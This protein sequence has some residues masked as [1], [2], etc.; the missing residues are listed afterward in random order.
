MSLWYPTA[1]VRRY[2]WD[3]GEMKGGAPKIVL[4]TTESSTV[5][6]YGGFLNIKNV[7]PHFTLD[8]SGVVFQ[9]HPIN[10]AA[11]ALRN[12]AGGVETNRQGRYCV[13]IEIVGYA[14]NGSKLPVK[15]MASLRALVKWIRSETGVKANYP[16]KIGG[17]FCYGYKS[18]CRMKYAYWPVFNGVCGHQHVPENTHWDPGA[19]NFA[20]LFVQPTPAQEVDLPLLP[21]KLGDGGPGNAKE[22]DVKALQSL[23]RMAAKRAPD[24]AAW[25]TISGKYDEKTKQRVAELLKTDGAEVGGVEW[26]ML[27][28]EAFADHDHSYHPKPVVT[29]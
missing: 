9:H 1:I 12:L 5:P 25:L 2:K 15:Q 22:Q 3:G 7:A 27:S 21:L 6:G 20:V 24:D 13:Q 26:V 14:K 23:L 10:R 18:S 11:R 8:R 29:V 16:S 4:H 19:F 17:E 28:A